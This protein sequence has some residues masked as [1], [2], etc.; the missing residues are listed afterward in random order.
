MKQISMSKTEV[1][2]QKRQ[3]FN[4]SLT[5]RCSILIPEEFKPGSIN[6][7]PVP[8]KGKSPPYGPRSPGSS[9]GRL[10]AIWTSSAHKQLIINKENLFQINNNQYSNFN[11]NLIF[12]IMKKQILLLVLVCFATVTAFGQMKTGSAPLPLVGCTNDALHPLAGVPYNY[13]ATVNPTG[14]N[15]QWWATKDFDFIKDNAGVPVN[16]SNTKL[17]VGTNLISASASYDATTTTDNV[18][19]TWSSA[20]I[21]GT[22]VASPTFVVVQ[23]DAASPACAN[24]L[25]VYPILPINGFTVDIKN[26]DQT[27][28]SLAYGASFS[29]CVSNIASA[30]YDAVAKAIVT[31]YGK[32]VLYFEVVA[33]NF[34]GSYTPSFQV[35]GMGTGQTVASLE[36]YTDAAFATTAIPTTLTAGTYSPALPLTVDPLVTNTTNGVSIY[37]KLTIANGTHETLTDDAIMLAVNGVNASGE[38]DVVN[39]ACNT[40]TDFEDTATQTLTKRPTVAAVAPGVFV[41]P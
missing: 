21:T 41:T 37:V 33:A 26:M 8:N 12:K 32:N 10:N 35:S 1:Q 2:N 13:K 14:G 11:N 28:T 22:T 38:K 25:K 39:T 4:D 16:N 29:T 20:T 5:H 19:I 23:Y 6:I 36:L 9:I 7:F 3:V 18:D 40:Q 34:T 24:N 15:F 30:K 27:K 17:T 31:D